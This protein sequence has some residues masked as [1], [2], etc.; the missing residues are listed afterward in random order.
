MS[1]VN[2]KLDAAIESLHLASCEAIKHGRWDDKDSFASAI[3]ILEA[4]GKIVGRKEEIHQAYM[5]MGFVANSA[6]NTYVN[7]TVGLAHA[8]PDDESSIPTSEKANAK[9][10]EG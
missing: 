10:K 4:A 8:L 7:L 2:N 6:V 3:R 9:A 5:N 1:E